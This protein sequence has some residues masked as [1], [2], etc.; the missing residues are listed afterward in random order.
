MRLFHWFWR[1]PSARTQ[2]AS[3]IAVLTDEPA[4][5]PQ[6]VSRRCEA[7]QALAALGEEGE[8]AS[9]AARAR[10]LEAFTATQAAERIQSIYA[11][12]LAV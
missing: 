12:A 2:V 1:G 4:A 10:Y 11:A 3:L 5:S 8:E 9:R 7:L 6:E